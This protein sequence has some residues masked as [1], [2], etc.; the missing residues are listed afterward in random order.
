MRVHLPDQVWIDIHPAT[1]GSRAIAYVLDFAIRWTVFAFCMLIFITVASM[2]SDYGFFDIFESIGS[3]IGESHTIVISLIV[4]LLFL[5]EW[6]YPIYFEVCHNGVTPGKKAM[7]LS[8]VNES[9]L[10]VTLEASILRTVLL[11]IDLMPGMGA[12][13]FF[14]MIFSERSQ[15]LGDLV[16]G[17]IVVYEHEVFSEEGTYTSTLDDNRKKITIPLDV[18]NVIDKFRRRRPELTSEVSAQMLDRILGVIFDICTD[19]DIP[20]LSTEKKKNKW[21]D[22][23]FHNAQPEKHTSSQKKNDHSINWRK[24]NEELRETEHAFTTFEKA[25]TPYSASKLL[26]IARSYRLVCQRYAYLSA[27]YPDTSEG[28]RAS[29]LVRLG[30][31]LIYSRRLDTLSEAEPSLLKRV[32]ASFHAIKWH[33]TISTL[34]GIGSGLITAAII[35]LDP[36]LAWLFLSEEIA[37]NLENGELWTESIQGMSSLASSQIMVNN[38]KVTLAA[39]ALGITGGVGTA[40]I[41]IFNG[42][43]LGGIFSALTHYNMA[44]RLLD[45]VVMH[46][47][48]ELSVIF[49]A[50]GCGLYLGDALISPGSRSRKQ[51]LRE[52][53]KIV[54]DLLLF[55][56]GCL[57]IAGL[58]EGFLSPYAIPFVIKLA[59]GASLGIVYWAFLLNILGKKKAS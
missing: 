25:T 15:R 10:P 26:H 59:F 31:R 43:H 4:L 54:I 12:V 52:H 30:R 58:V 57:V 22:T 1:F 5:V 14:S 13:A 45:F 3:V 48:L 27:F 16:A 17:T 32:P 40:A 39:F 37:Q 36:N 53:G 49:V 11:I 28:M 38:I 50:G 56:A 47:F 46:G 34:L 21:L 18:Y 51:A 35:Q 2:L 9:G 6:S 42:V 19:L 24:I 33:C 20:D 7:G 8:V 29:R 55:N 41:M 23:F 44:G